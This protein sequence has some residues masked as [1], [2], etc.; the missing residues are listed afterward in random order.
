[1]VLIAVGDRRPSAKVLIAVAALASVSMTQSSSLIMLLLRLCGRNSNSNRRQ[2]Q[3]TCKTSEKATLC[4][5][6]ADSTSVSGLKHGV[7]RS[8]LVHGNR[9]QRN[10]H[11]GRVVVYATVCGY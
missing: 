11:G 10:K 9:L 5:C 7:I 4:G 3:C 6:Y 1:V 2:Y 8:A